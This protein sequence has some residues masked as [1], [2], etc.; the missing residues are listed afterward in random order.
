MLL[1]MLVLVCLETMVDQIKLKVCETHG[2]PAVHARPHFKFDENPWLMLAIAVCGVAVSF[3]LL[4]G[5]KL[6]CY[7]F[8][9]E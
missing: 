2:I 7:L 5:I 8:G 6:D 9:L 3:A 1:Q 4:G